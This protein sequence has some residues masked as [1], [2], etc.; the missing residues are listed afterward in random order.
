[1]RGLGA[2]LALA[3]AIA[4]PG[5]IVAATTSSPGDEVF[6]ISTGQIANGQSQTASA[7][8]SFGAIDPALTPA[9]AAVSGAFASKGI[10]LSLLSS[11]S[12]YMRFAQVGK[13]NGNCPVDIWLEDTAKGTVTVQSDCGTADVI[14]GSTRIVYSPLT[15][16][17]TV[18]EA[19]ASLR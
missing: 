3:A 9:M 12:D 1:M 18:R 11:G 14:V 4:L 19:A 10:E 6:R 13:V 2:C 8:G 5:V 16:G 15:A 7:S 17:R